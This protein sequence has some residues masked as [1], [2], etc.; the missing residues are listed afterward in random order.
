MRK[1]ACPNCGSNKGIYTT[2][3]VVQY[4]DWN[5]EPAGYSDDY[6]DENRYAKCMNCGKRFLLKK[7]REGEK[8]G[9]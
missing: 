8:N 6:E 7:V 5:G 1:M 4:Y 3:K 9:K 2:I